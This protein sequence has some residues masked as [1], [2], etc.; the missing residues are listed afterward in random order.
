MNTHINSNEDSCS[1]DSSFNNEDQLQ[2]VH[3]NQ[4]SYTN[5][6]SYALDPFTMESNPY[7]EMVTSDIWRL[8]EFKL[9]PTGFTLDGC[10]CLISLLTGVK[11]N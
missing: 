7:N 9:P 6:N 4:C 11:L 10:S 8:D 3:M 2:K 1:Y 5:F